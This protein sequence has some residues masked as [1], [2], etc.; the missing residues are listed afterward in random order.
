MG[1]VDPQEVAEWV[2][3]TCEAQGVPV[4]V[5]DPDVVRSVAVLLSGRAAGPQPRGS[6][7]GA[8]RTAGQSRQVGCTRW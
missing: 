6:A 2:S 3:A 1:R 8:R 4:R 7:G 5:T